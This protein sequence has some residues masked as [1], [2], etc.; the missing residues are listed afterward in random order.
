[1]HGV[2]RLLIG[3]VARGRRAHER[4][5][6]VMWMMIRGLTAVGLAVFVLVP[7]TG[8]AGIEKK[9]KNTGI[10]AALGVVDCPK[11]WH[12]E[13]SRGGAR[14]VLG[15]IITGPV[16]CGTNV[17]VRYLGVAADL[18]TLPWGDNV[19]KPNA[20]DRKPPVRLP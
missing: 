4:T 3:C 5:F 10:N 6:E 18:V 14:G 8:H 15:A 13:A 12:D 9:A 17:A 16:M 7:A 11:A 2:R 20:L 19:V 1:M